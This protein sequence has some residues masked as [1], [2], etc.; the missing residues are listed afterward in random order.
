MVIVDPFKAGGKTQP[1]ICFQESHQIIV[2]RGIHIAELKAVIGPLMP[3]LKLPG[4]TGAT[5]EDTARSQGV[6]E[7]LQQLAKI[8]QKLDVV[9]KESFWKTLV[10]DRDRAG[11]LEVY[12]AP[13]EFENKAQVMF[14][15]K[16]VAQS[17]HPE[18]PNQERRQLLTA[19]FVTSLKKSLT[20]RC[21]FTTRGGNYMGSGP[22]RSRAGDIA[23]VLY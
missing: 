19:P 12:P 13:G 18:L 7:V 3:V 2:A 15:D 16:S 10:M 14:E 6:G 5:V 4:D 22:Y 11:F 1:G 8:L 21:F 9:S 20:H 17:F 23:V